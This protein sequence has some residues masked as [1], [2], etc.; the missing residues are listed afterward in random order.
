MNR[1]NIKLW[2]FKKRL[3]IFHKNQTQKRIIKINVKNEI[4]SLKEYFISRLV[5]IGIY[6]CTMLSR[7]GRTSK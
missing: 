4:I 3:L 5:R 1:R 7:R 6:M 2:I